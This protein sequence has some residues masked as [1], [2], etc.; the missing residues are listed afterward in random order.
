MRISVYITADKTSREKSNDYTTRLI[1]LLSASR[2]Y[3]SFQFNS[4]HGPFMQ[5]AN[6]A[7]PYV[8]FIVT[9]RLVK[10]G[11]RLA[12]VPII[13]KSIHKVSTVITYTREQSRPMVFL[14][15]Q[16]IRPWM[17]I[18][19]SCS[20]GHESHHRMTMATAQHPRRR[21]IRQ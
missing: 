4:A 2:V 19:S 13:Q 18:Q 9:I 12:T 16:E 21:H 11:L 6:L 5:G 15:L 10:G 14:D 17:D 20:L 3:K 7:L 8:D 1:F